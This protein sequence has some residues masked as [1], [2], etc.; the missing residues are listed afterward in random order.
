MNELT[1]ESIIKTVADYFRLPVTD[2]KSYCRKGEFVRA[3]HIAMY[4]CS[5]LTFKSHREIG[6]YFTVNENY[7]GK[8]HSTVFYGVKKIKEALVLY[9][10][11]QGYISDLS[12]IF[13]K[14]MELINPDLVT[15]D[16]FMENDYYKNK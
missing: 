3:R 7:N 12:E 14:Q 9:T 2:V 4:F 11:Y 5:E 16:I 8:D 13:Q 6:I 10:V 15:D 1:I